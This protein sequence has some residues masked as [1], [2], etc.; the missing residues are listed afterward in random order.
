M[1]DLLHYAIKQAETFGA[2]EA[3]AYTATNNESEVFIENND[4]KQAKSQ[5]ISSIGIRVV[6]DGSIG[7]YSINDL[8]KS[9]I[10][11][12]AAMA[13]K[14]AQASPRDRHNILPNRSRSKSRSLRGIYDRNS[15]SFQTSDAAGIG[16]GDA[17]S[18]QVV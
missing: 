3:E 15:E 4:V 8:A 5:S 18:C 2:S 10:R 7:F 14:I 9:R 16:S 11:D 17:R 1:L 6:L 12:G 13:I